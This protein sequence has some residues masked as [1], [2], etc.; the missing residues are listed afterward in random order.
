MP[1]QV[2]EDAVLADLQSH[3]SR[4]DFTCDDFGLPMPSDFDFQAYRLR[5]L[6]AELDYDNAAE[7][8][9]A[10][11]MRQCM[12]PFPLQAKAFDDIK[13]AIDNQDS[14]IFLSMVL[15]AQ[16]NPFCSKQS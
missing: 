14:R 2:A 11:Q 12:E 13:C 1:P 10:R 3:L 4:H 6:R 9:R 15:A 8:A 16:A 5:E 7:A